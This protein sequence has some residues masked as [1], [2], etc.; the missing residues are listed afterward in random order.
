M[1]VGIIS[2]MGGWRDAGLHECHQRDCVDLRAGQAGRLRRH[3]AGARCGA[4]IVLAW[5]GKT[6]AGPISGAEGPDAPRRYQTT[7]NVY[8]GA[9]PEEQRRAN[10]AV[11][12]MVIQ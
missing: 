9:L 8:G 7:M 4:P 12:G 1:G 2:A 5:G 10:S 3:Q 11:V 6:G